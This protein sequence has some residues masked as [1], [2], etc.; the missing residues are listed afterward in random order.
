MNTLPFDLGTAYKPP[1]SYL[2]KQP[3]AADMPPC[4]LEGY[5]CSGSSFSSGF[6]GFSSGF[7]GFS[8][9]FLRSLSRIPFFFLHSLSRTPTPSTSFS[10]HSYSPEGIQPTGS[11]F[12]FSLHSPAGR[13]SQ[14][15]SYNQLSR[16]SYEWLEPGR[17]AE[18]AASELPPLSISIPG[19][20]GMR[21]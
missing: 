6:S 20:D 8:S 11:P 7:S 5:K 4:S 16:F 14:W 18:G 17:S 10:L 13:L 12:H 15:H 2:Q 19:G 1:N 9:F 21:R 3:E